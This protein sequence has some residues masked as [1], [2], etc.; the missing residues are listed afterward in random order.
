MRADESFVN[1]AEWV[2]DEEEPKS[3]RMVVDVKE[4]AHEDQVDFAEM[5][6]MFKQGVAANVDEADHES[7]Y[8]LGVAYKEMGLLDE[9]ISEFQKSLRGAAYRVRS[10]EALGQCF[11]E[12]EQYQIA[13][14][15]LTRALGDADDADDVLIGVLYL[16]GLASEKVEHWK[17][18]QRF[19]Q[20]VCAVDIQFRDVRDRLAAV[21]RRAS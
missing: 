18:A 12:K 5:L 13:V 11:V 19:Y 3:T 15:I 4:P 2:R 17:D 1:L 20:R 14:T 9:A 7:H 10:Y 21:E 6:A 16:L 8:D